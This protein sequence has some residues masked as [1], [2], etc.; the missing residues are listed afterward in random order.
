MTGLVEEIRKYVIGRS[1][2]Y[3]ETSE[4]HYDFWNEH[5]RYVYQEAV[6]LASKYGA[7]ETAVALGALLHDIALI[8]RA[9]SRKDHHLNGKILSNEI[10]DRF[11][12]PGDLKDRVLGCVLNH[13]SSQSAENT[14]ELCV[15]DADIL[16]H[17]DNIPMLFNCAFNRDGVSL[18][19]VRAWMQNAFEHD[20]ND[21][22][23]RTKEAFRDRYNTIKSI[24]LGEMQEDGEQVYL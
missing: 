22:S 4:D 17:F 1:E 6:G 9:G 20:Y 18:N 12:C 3:R 13:R 11:N 10:L 2:A 19:E 15:C 24:V 16:A 14:E 7:D 23:E 8:E 5:I 21:L